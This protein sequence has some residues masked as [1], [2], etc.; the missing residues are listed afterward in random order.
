MSENIPK[1]Q[2]LNTFHLNLSHNSLFYK[3][4]K[5]AEIFTTFL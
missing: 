4:I 1:L 3:D 2:S 5:N